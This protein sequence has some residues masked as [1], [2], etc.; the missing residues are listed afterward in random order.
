MSDPAPK[1]IADNVLLAS[2]IGMPLIGGG[3]SRLIGGSFMLVVR[4]KR[5][6]ERQ[7]FALV[8]ADNYSLSIMRFIDE[9]HRVIEDLAV[10]FPDQSYDVES[11]IVEFKDLGVQSTP[12]LIKQIARGSHRESLSAVKRGI[13]MI[14][15][16]P[17]HKFLDEVDA[18]VVRSGLNKRDA[19]QIRKEIRAARNKIVRLAH[20]QISADVSRDGEY[21]A[22]FAAKLKL[23]VAL[24]LIGA[25]IWFYLTKLA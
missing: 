24:V 19:K 23:G 22:R 6:T 16:D 10:R 2:A 14:L 9:T 12:A 13:G 18:R 1:N 17:L 21:S 25:G 20:A 8:W 15:V 4:S 3:I 7:A 5:W 11:A